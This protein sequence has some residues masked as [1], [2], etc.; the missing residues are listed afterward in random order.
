MSFEDLDVPRY[1]IYSVTRTL[2]SLVR[3]S[4]KYVMVEVKIVIPLSS[5]LERVVYLFMLVVTRLM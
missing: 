2:V 1:M 4:K 5:N 3:V